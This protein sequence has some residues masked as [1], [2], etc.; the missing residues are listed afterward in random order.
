MLNSSLSIVNIIQ[1]L[2]PQ[3]TELIGDQAPDVDRQLA[4]LLTQIE[5]EPDAQDRIVTLLRSYQPVMD[6][7]DQNFQEHLPKGVTRSTFDLLA[8]DPS[9]VHATRYIC[10]EC[11][12]S[13][14][15]RH[16][17]Q[18]PEPCTDHDQPVPREPA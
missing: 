6:W 7:V 12:S 13:W 4:D 10:P 5:T 15:R 17:S 9:S 16:V 11:G 2:R 18:A 1:S 3:L 8:G 14:F